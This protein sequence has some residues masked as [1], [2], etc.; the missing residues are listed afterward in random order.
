V[1]MQKMSGAISV[2]LDTEGSSHVFP[3]V[4]RR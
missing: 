4:L 2:T 1:Q 3:G